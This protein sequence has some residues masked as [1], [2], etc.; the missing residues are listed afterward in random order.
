MSSVPVMRHT[1][2]MHVSES[3][4]RRHRFPAEIISH[5][6]WLYFRFSLSSTHL[7]YAKKIIGKAKLLYKLA[8]AAK[9]EPNG[10]VKDVIYPAVGEKVLEDLIQEA[11]A[12]EKH[13]HRVKLVT[14][15]SYSHHYRRI[16]K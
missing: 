16:V 11:E 3:L 9:G 5:C 2:E 7:K 4:Y 8:K 1:F 14:R 12:D 10:V 15:T 13:E 6:F